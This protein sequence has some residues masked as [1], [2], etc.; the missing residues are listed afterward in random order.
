HG[1]NIMSSDFVTIATFTTLPEA[2]AARM[3]IE[4]EGIPAVVT[5]AEIVNMDWLLGNAVG[6]LQL[7]GPP[8]NAP[9]AIALLAPIAA[10]RSARLEREED[11][12]TDDSTCLACGAEL[13][14]DADRCPACD[15][16]WTDG[17][18]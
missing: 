10:E 13:P 8:S 17:R 2:E 11:D 9:A 18:E 5:D 3:R 1:G 16:S 14:E 6:Y 12:D 7:Q 15:W 4:A